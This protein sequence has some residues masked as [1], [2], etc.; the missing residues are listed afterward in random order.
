MKPEV[1]ETFQAMYQCR[2]NVLSQHSGMH[3]KVPGMPHHVSF[4]RI[5]Q[6]G[7]ERP[8]HFWTITQSSIFGVPQTRR[9]P[10]TCLF[11]SA[12]MVTHDD[13]HG[14]LALFN[15]KEGDVEL[16]RLRHRAMEL[17]RSARRRVRWYLL[18]RQNGTQLVN[19]LH[20]LNR[21]LGQLTIPMFRS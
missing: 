5:I 1:A 17:W 3:R 20:K 15:V 7:H 21:H 8:T 13:M 11:A 2:E 4:A 6:W 12:A 16:A 10:S 9:R 18:L 14:T 19:I